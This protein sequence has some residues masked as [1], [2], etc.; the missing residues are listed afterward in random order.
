MEKLEEIEIYYVIL[1]IFPSEY[2]DLGLENTKEPQN[3][4]KNRQT[5]RTLL[6]TIT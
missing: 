2:V 4:L 1:H 6:M 3:N 5:D